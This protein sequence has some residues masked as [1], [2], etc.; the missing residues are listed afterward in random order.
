MD[1]K[2]KTILISAAVLAVIGSVYPLYRYL[3][4]K[5]LGR[6]DTVLAQAP[7]G[8]AS[9]SPD[10]SRYLFDGSVNGGLTAAGSALTVP[11]PAG[12]SGFSGSAS[13]SSDDEAA[14]S[15]GPADG[16]A[17]PAVGKPAPAAGSAGAQSLEQGAW[18]SGSGKS[19]DGAAIV[20]GGRQASAASGG[21]K[22]KSSRKPRSGAG[23]G[24][25][26]AGLPAE[27][28]TG[29]MTQEQSDELVS[30]FKA[31]R[32]TPF[33]LDTLIGLVNSGIK[34]TEKQAQIFREMR[35]KD[36]KKVDAEMKKAA[37]TPIV[38]PPDLPLRR[39]SFWPVKGRISQ[40]FGG[41]NWAVY[42]GRTY[43]GVYYPHFHNGLDI[44]A[45]V[46]SPLHSLDAGRVAAVGG[47]RSTGVYVIVAH[48]DGL[49]TTYMHM[50]V[51][52][53]TVSPGQYVG[54]NQVV[55]SIGMTGM[56]TGPHVHFVV[57]QGDVIDPLRVLP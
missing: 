39:G 30:R 57:R 41:V 55:G 15:A 32:L 17:V 50:P 24:I 21:K 11:D 5:S 6:A 12:V 48:P 31:G 44:A 49:A 26:V 37:E 20:S 13:G 27:A 25:A 22:P 16:A 53:P 43:N 28:F 46:G 47:T 2:K 40:K 34:F 45:P 19:Y 33:Q 52:G 36:E 38:L 9:G 1:R 8:A 29:G 14:A 35:A 18:R 3:Q 42:S 56:T 10:S 23:S 4:N 51:G 7:R 54:A